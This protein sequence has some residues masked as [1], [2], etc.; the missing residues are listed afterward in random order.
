[1]RRHAAAVALFFLL[2]PP[3]ARAQTRLPAVFSDH[4]VLQREAAVPVWGWATPGA[5]VSVRGDWMAEAA[6]AT[7]SSA[8]NWKLILHTPPAGGPHTLTIG[9]RTLQ[10]VWSGE[11]WLCSGQ[12]N[13]EWTVGTPPWGGRGVNDWESEVAQAD[14]PQLR[15][16]DVANAVA[17]TPRDDTSGAWQ[18]CSP[19][20]AGRFSACAYFFGR[21]LQREL[22]VPI[23]L[24]TADWGGTVAEAWTSAPGLASFPEFQDALKAVQTASEARREPLAD[25]QRLW[26]T[27]LLE[28]DPGSRENWQ[29]ASSVGWSPMLLPATW[30]KDGLDQFD[31]VVWFRIDLSI[32]LDW[33][34]HA[35]TLELGPIDDMDTTWVSGQRVGGMEDDGRWQTPRRYEV[36][37]ELVKTTLLPVAVR[38]VDTGGNGGLNGKP[39]EMRLYPAGDES[40]AIPIATEWYWKRGAALSDIG[41]YPRDGDDP[42]QPSVLYNGMIAP[43]VGYGMRGVIWYQGESNRERAAQYRRL[44]PALIADWRRLWG[45]GDFPW[46]YVQIAPFRYGGDTGQAAELREAQ[47]A[48]LAVRNTGMAVTM[49]I[50]DPDDIHPTN[51]QD[52]GKR[53]ALWALAKTYAKSGIECSGPLYRGMKVEGGRIRLQFDHAQGLDGHGKPLEGFTIAGADHVFHP[54]AAEIDGESVLVSSPE[55]PKPVAVRYGW[56]AEAMP[57]LFNQAGLPASSFRTDD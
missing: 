25:R 38:V 46:Y 4:M 35:L 24:I 22:G 20:T 5:S 9:D 15:V 19:A 8:G 29:S 31:G 17:Y 36:P 21:E 30:S 51:K 39:A 34:G 50:G 7:A 33:V 23:G 26:W 1:M 3:A 45:I 56:V 16:Y 54:A 47:R 11:V 44:F 10:D 14:F 53:L 27:K 2:L 57:N 28:T 43:L 12:S 48:T 13:M 32:P 6:T 40:A 52:V 18:V 41:A 55:V 49:D 42:N 37:G